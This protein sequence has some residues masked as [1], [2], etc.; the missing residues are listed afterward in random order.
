MI[1][2]YI[3]LYA[4]DKEESNLIILLIMNLSVTYNNGM[5]ATLSK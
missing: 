4:N 2:L 3:S 1:N 5:A